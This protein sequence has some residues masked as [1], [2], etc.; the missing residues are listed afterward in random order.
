MLSTIN[1]FKR[2]LRKSMSKSIIYLPQIFLQIYLISTLII[3]A[4]GPVQYNLNQPQIFWGYMALYHL[5]FFLGFYV[6]LLLL[7]KTVIKKQKYLSNSYNIYIFYAVFLL[8]FISSVLSFKGVDSFI[9]LINPIFWIESAVSGILNPQEVYLEKMERVFSSNQGNKLLNIVLFFISFSKIMLLPFLVFFWERI[10]VKLKVATLFIAL[11]P[12]LSS[13]SNGTNKGV[14]DFILLSVSALVAFFIYNKVHS[15]SFGFKRRKFFLMAFLIAFLGGLTFFGN[16]MISRGG[17]LTYIEK[18]DPLGRI[19]VTDQALER[20]DNFTYYTYG[21]L[22]TYIVQGYY[23][24]SIALNEEFDSTFGVGNSVFLTRNFQE[25]LGI[26]IID[27]TYQNKIDKY[28]DKDAQWHS[29][30]SYF[31]NDFHFF[32]VIFVCFLLSFYMARIWIDF[33]STGNIFAG[34][35]VSVFFIMIIFIPANNQIFGFLDG[36]SAFVITSLLW[37]LSRLKSTRVY[38]MREKN[39]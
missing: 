2:Q 5:S 25:L 18:V 28:W 3:F 11:L 13:L 16:A 34:V 15:S 22:S 31:A 30:Y 37:Y 8:A 20:Q 23:G 12:L 26:N 36:I 6:S 14:F 32:G 35:L 9:D 33:L 7:N 10:S 29:M 39:V 38:F 4:F 1:L 24:F 27:R 19:E 17:D 21:W